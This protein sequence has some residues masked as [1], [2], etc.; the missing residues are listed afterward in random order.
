[1]RRWADAILVAATVLAVFAGLLLAGSA[2]APADALAWLAGHGGDRVGT[3]LLQVRLPRVALAFLVGAALAMAGAALQALLANP[4]ADPFL[5]GIS[6]GGAAAATA[7]FALLP[8]ALLGMVP[9][10][11][12]GGAALA[13]ALVW[14]MAHGPLGPSPTRMI[15]AGVAV[16]AAAS[17]A[18]LTILAIVPSPRL[19]G[20]LAITMGSFAGATVPAVLWLLPYLVL[21]ALLLVLHGRDLGLLAVGEESASA[22]GVEVASVR[23]RVFLAAAALAGGAVAFAGV[24]GFVG[25]ITPHLCR[26]I[27]GHQPRRMVV[28]AALAGG[29]LTVLGDLAARRVLAPAELPVGVVTALLGVPFFVALLR[30]SS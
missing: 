7:A 25:L 19:A 13:T 2:V 30:R 11:A 21:P 27:W 4:L 8:A 14:W 12:M 24:I 9:A 10:L 16:N 29:A 17:A 26:L 18:I 15:L 20:A 28:R 1:V 22:L 6:G 3:I 23:R 5:L